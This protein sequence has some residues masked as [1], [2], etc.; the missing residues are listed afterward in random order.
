M[1]SPDSNPD[2]AASCNHLRGLFDRARK[3]V[4]CRPVPH[5]ATGHVHRR[6][7]I[8]ERERNA[9]PRPAP[10]LDPV[11]TAVRPRCD[12]GFHGSEEFMDTS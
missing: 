8:A 5:T 2:A 7:R 4:D 9:P 12:P 10:R 3:I 11:T 6:S 1:V